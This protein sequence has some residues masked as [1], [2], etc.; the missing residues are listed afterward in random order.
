M[1]NRVE[2]RWRFERAWRFGPAI[3]LIAASVVVVTAVPAA[4]ALRGSSHD[5]SPPGVHSE[6]VRHASASSERK[7]RRLDPPAINLPPGV[8][9]VARL[10]LP[11]GHPF[12]LTLQR[13]RFEG[14]QYVCLAVTETFHIAPGKPEVSIASTG[15]CEGPLPLPHKPLVAVM[16]D[17][18]ACKPRPAQLVWGLALKGVTVALRSRGREQVAVRRNIPANLHARGNVFF[19]WSRA[20]PDSLVARDPAGRAIETYVINAR[21]TPVFATECKLH[22]PSGSLGPVTQ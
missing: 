10:R 22:P 14:R 21:R 6:L 7:S 12:R 5:S 13:I 18:T 11:D 9:T 8:V 2:S 17:P 1:R 4:F 19:V 16:G 20:A 3:L 15:Q